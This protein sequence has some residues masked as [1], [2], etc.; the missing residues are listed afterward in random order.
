MPETIPFSERN[1]QAQIV[2]ALVVPFIFGAIVGVVLG[3][4]APAYWILSALAALGAVLAGLEHPDP[5]SAAIRGFVM[6]AVYG[7]GVLLAHAVAGT[8]AEVS[9]GSF[10]PIVILIDALAGAILAAI[11]GLI[12]RSRIRHSA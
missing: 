6:G 1:R 7:V 3:A 4:S 11:G 10:P 2:L 8:H 5:R 12:S 9:L